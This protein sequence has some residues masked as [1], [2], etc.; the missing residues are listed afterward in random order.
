MTHSIRIAAC[1]AL[2]VLGAC[3][4][5][6][7]WR[8]VPVAQLGALLPCK[9]DHAERRVEL[10]GAQHPLAMSGC[11]AGGALF[12]VSQ[13]PIPPGMPPE[14]LMAAWRAAVVGNMRASQAQAV[15]FT[16]PPRRSEGSAAPNVM[17]RVVG[18]QADG[19]AVQGQLAWFSDGGVLYHLAVF[20]PALTP[21]M[22]EP[23]FTEV[24]W[25]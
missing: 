14:S 24:Q 13:M 21:A 3:S 8:Q 10:L 18:Q 6:L 2:L 9:P 11:E 16:P 23:F 19:G 1:V 25:L 15:A 20:G 4:P 22:L 17:L 7:N 5:S 12:A